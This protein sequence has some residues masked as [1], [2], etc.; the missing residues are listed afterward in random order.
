[1]DSIFV[2]M[3]AL[4][5][6]GGAASFNGTKDR[7]WDESISF[8]CRLDII[9]ER[10]PCRGTGSGAGAGV[11]GEYESS[12]PSVS[13]SQRGSSSFRKAVPPNGSAPSVDG[14]LVEVL[15]EKMLPL[16]DA[17]FF[18]TPRKDRVSSLSE[19]DRSSAIKLVMC[20]LS[21]S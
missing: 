13:S 8:G 16:L 7:C 12:F 21:P 14:R 19:S 9:L 15:L 6:R 11:M 1:M 3:L 2:N 17:R 4:F 5:G 10:R 20:P 18:L